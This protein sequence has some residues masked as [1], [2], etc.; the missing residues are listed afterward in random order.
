VL[1]GTREK[2][3]YVQQ[4]NSDLESHLADR[5]NGEIKSETDLSKCFGKRE[6]STDKCIG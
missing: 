1:G 2:L 4:Q 6:D 3:G 5:Y